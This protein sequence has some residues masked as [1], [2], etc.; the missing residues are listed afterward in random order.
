MNEDYFSRVVKEALLGRPNITQCRNRSQCCDNN[1]ITLSEST[2][3][4][5]TEPIS[6][7]CPCLGQCI[8]NTDN[9]I[10]GVVL[11]SGLEAKVDLGKLSLS[12]S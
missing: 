12:I 1:S 9:E 6:E 11:Q 3:V 4:S 7:A 2:R 10:V 8:F 5:P